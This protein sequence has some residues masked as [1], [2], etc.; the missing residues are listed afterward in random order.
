M[1]KMTRYAVGAM[2][3]TAMRLPG[4]ELDAKKMPGHWVLAR[5]G[6]R[7][8]RPGGLS[9]TTQML[10]A[11]DITGKDHV[12]ELAPGFG[13]TANLILAKHPATY[14]GV[15]RERG[16]ATTLAW[17]IGTPTT[18]VTHGAADRTELPAERATVVCGEAILTMQTAAAKRRIVAE[19]FRLLKPG[20]RYAIHELSLVPNSLP[21]EIRENIERE[22]SASIH[23]GARPLTQSEWVSLLTDAGF[24]T[25]R[26]LEAPMHLLR[27]GR[28]LEDESLPRTLRFLANVATHGVERRRVVEMA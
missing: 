10:D 5:L 28:L 22:L 20:G 25:D 6:K 2:V 19:A 7:V 1:P 26:A 8:L 15:E 14:M 9:L 3:D 18:R 23:V 24:V 21:L 16:I 12:V 13:S 4:S 11:V 27:F 17:R